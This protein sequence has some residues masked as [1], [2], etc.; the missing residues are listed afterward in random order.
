MISSREEEEE[1]RRVVDSPFY[2]YIYLIIRP[3][4]LSNREIHGTCE[5]PW[6]SFTRFFWAPPPSILNTL[7]HTTPLLTTSVYFSQIHQIPTHKAILQ[8]AKA[9]LLCKPLFP[10]LSLFPRFPSLSS[11]PLPSL[12]FLISLQLHHFSFP[13]LGFCWRLFLFPQ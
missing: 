8:K 13:Q 10:L 9:L 12:L 11:P 2:V 1:E 5:L 7:L 3:K 4:Q 6:W